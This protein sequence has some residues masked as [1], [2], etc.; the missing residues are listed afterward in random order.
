LVELNLGEMS[1]Q[2]VVGSGSTF[3]FTVPVDD[4]WQVASRYLDRLSR[5]CDDGPTMVSLVSVSCPESLS[6][7]DAKSEH[8]IH[9]FLNFVLRSHD[10]GIQTHSG[11][12]LLMVHATESELTEFVKRLGTETAAVNRNR[13]QG[14][15]P[16]INTLVIGTHDVKADRMRLKKIVHEHAKR[17]GPRPRS[18]SNK[19]MQHA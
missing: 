15:L 11:H 17:P 12:W 8:E 14:P 19:R 5:D 2:S 6:A 1:L 7:A 16:D 9:L 3:S 10:L 18:R 13:P 4:A